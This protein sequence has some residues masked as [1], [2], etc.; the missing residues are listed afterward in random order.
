MKK[1]PNLETERLVLSEVVQSDVPNIVLHANNRNVTDN[2][3][4]LPFPYTEKDAVD[5]IRIINK[6]F[7]NEDQ[8]AFAIRRKNG[9][10]FIG[11]IGLTISLS[12]NRAELGYWLAE[13]FWNKGLITEAVQRLLKFGFE[14]LNLN[15]I[16]AVYLSSN[17]ASGKVMVKNGMIKEGV[18]KDHDVKKDHSVYE[19]K[20]VS[21]IQ[22]RLLKSEYESL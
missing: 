13:P 16:I 4:S 22:Y 2:T 6:G 12:N 8:Y 1:F 19:G 20:Y 21:L 14:N 15:K 10:E 5:W 17:E 7:H 9:L 11:A 3:R 18:F